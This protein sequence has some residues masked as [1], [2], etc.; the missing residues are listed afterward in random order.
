VK[1]LRNEHLNYLM[2]ENTSD[3]LR[4]RIKKR[5]RVILCCVRATRMPTA[6]RL[7]TKLNVTRVTKEALISF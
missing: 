3:V 1:V 2:I 5:E 4:D 6:S 7:M